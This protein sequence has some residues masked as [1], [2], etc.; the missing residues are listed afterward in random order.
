MLVYQDLLT[1]D[2]LLSDSFPYK[3]IEN[4]ILWEVEGKWTTVGAVDVNIGA[5]P[6]AEEGGEDEGVDDT[7]QKV[8][9]I[10]DTFRLQEQPTYDKKGFIA[11]IKKYIKLLTPKLNEE[12]QAAFKKGIEGATKFLLPKLNDFQ[13]FVGEGMHDDSTLVFAYY[14]E[15]ATNPTFLYFGHGLKEISKEVITSLLSP[16]H[17]LAFE[18]ESS[19]HLSL[20]LAPQRRSQRGQMQH[21]NAAAATA[22]YDAGPANDAGDAVMARW[23]QSAGLQHLASPTG[24]NDQRHLPSLLMQGYGAQTAEENQRLF[25]LMRNLNLNGESSESYTPTAAMPSSEGFFSPDFRGDFG[26]GL[27]DLHA[28]DDTELLSEHVSTEPFEPSPFMPSVDKEFE[29]GFNFPTNRQQQTDAEP[30]GS[31]PKSEKENNSVAKIKV[32]VRKRPLNKKETARKEDDVVTVSDN[33]LTVHEPKLKV[34]LTAYVERHEFCFDAVLDEDVSNDEV[35]R[36]TIEP[37]IPIIFQRTKAT[38]F[39]YGQTG[40]GKTYTM[41]PLPIRAVEDLMRL[42]RQPVYSNQ[43]FKLWLSYFEIYGGK[44]FDLLSERKKLLMREDGRQQV[45][46]VGLQEYEVSDVQIVKELIDKGNAERS[47]GSTGANEESSRSHAILQL[48]VKKHVEVKQTRRKNN[49]ATELPGKV[50]GKISFIDLAGSE[51]GADTTDNDRQTR[52]EG[53]EINK[54]LLALKE[55][56]RALDNDQLHIPFRGS[57]LTEVLRDSFVGNSRT[58]MISCISPSVGSCEHTVNTLR[59]ADRVKSLSKSGNSKKDLT[60]NS[61]PPVN[62]DSLLGS[63]DV[64][65]IFEP[66]QVV[67]VQETGR[68]VEKD[69][70][71]ASGIDFRQPTN[72]REESGIPSISM[73]KSRSET[74]NAFGGSNSQRNHLSSYPQETSDREEKAKKVSPPR[75]KGLREEK[76]DRPPQN[77]SSY[78]KETSDREEKVKKVSPPRGKGLR[79]EKPDRPPQNLSSYAKETSDRE[80]KVSPPRGKVLREE[81]P[82]RPPQNLSSYPQETSDREEKAKKVSPPRGKGL[83]EEKPDRPQ[84]LSKREVRSSDIPTFTNFRQNTSET[85]SRQYETEEN[86]DALLEEEEALITA[87]RKEI[88]DTMEI[89]REEMKLLA[90]VDKP[91]SMI[92]NY[93]TQLSFVLSRKAAGLVSLQARLARF[94]HRLKEQEILSLALSQASKRRMKRYFSDLGKHFPPLLLSSLFASDMEEQKLADDRNS[95]EQVERIEL[96]VSD[97]DARDTE[98]EVFEEAIDSSKPESFQADDGLHEDLP[99]EEVKV[100]EVN[101][102][103]HGEANLQHITTGEAATGFVTSQMN[104]DEGEAGA[105]NVN[106]TSTLSFSENGT[107]FPE[108]KQV[109]AEVIEETTNDGIEEENKEETVDVSGAQRNGERASGERSFSDSIQVA[110]AGTPSPSEKSSSEENGETEGRISREHDTVQNGGL[111]VEHTSQPNKDFEK[112]QGSSVNI[113]PEVKERKSEVASSVSPTES[114]SNTAASPPA[115]PAGLGRDAPLLEP[116]PRVPHQPRVNGNASQNQSEQAEDPTTAETD[117]HD[118]TREKLQLIRVKFL[119]LSHRLGQTPHNVVV[120]QVLYRLG[121]A[122]Q[123]R[124]RNGSRV[125]AFSF[126]RASSM[127]EQLEAAGQ[128]PLDFSCTVMV[129]GKSGVG[130]SATINSIFDEVKI[131]TDAFQMGT[132]RVQEVEGF[133]QG[134]KVRVIDTPGLLPSWSDQHKNEKMLKSVKAFIK[135]NP[136]DIVLYLDRLDMQSRDSGDTP[137]LRTITDVF[138]PSIWFNAIV[139]LTHAASAPPD[140]PNGTASSYDMFVTQRSHVI[141][142]A[143]RQAAGDMRLMNPV[144]LVENHSACR[145]NRAGQ[146]VLPNGQVWKPHLLLL[147]FASKILAEANALLKLQDNNTPGRPF[148]AR[149]K[150]PPL[151]LLLSSFLQSRP[152]AKLP[153]EQYGDEEDE[154][155]LDESSGSDEESE[156]D[157]LPPFKRLTKSEMAR[158]SK[159]QKK[160]YLDEMEYREKLF[161]KR[162]MKE[163]RKRRKMLKKF[164]AEIKEFANGHS[165]NVEEERSEPASVPVPMPDLSLPASFDSDNPTH[166]YRSLDS[167][168]QWLV[169]PVLE[170]QGWDH[171]VGYEGVNAER[172]FVVKEKIPISFS[173]QVTK[174]KKD[175]NVQLEM[176]SSVKHGEGRSTSLGFEMQNAGKELAYTVRSDTRFNNFRKHKAA[177]GLSVTLLGD[178]VSA[179][180]KVEDKLIANKRFRMVMCGGAMTSRGDV[181][182]GGSLEAQLRDKDYPLG[183][184]LSTLGLSLMDWHGDLAIGGNIQSQV[185]IG[186]SSNLIARANLNNRGTGQ[187]SVRV[188]SSEQLQLAMVALVPLFKKLFSY[189][190]PQQMQY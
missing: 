62:K 46:I 123:L 136:P 67:N 15:G 20:K 137:L 145:T 139:G 167:S 144:S 186:R 16:V 146:R 120:A 113:S 49:D 189:Y 79:E 182:Y 4:G 99:S 14:K 171:D 84:N 101:G 19:P 5:N 66:P 12:D 112:Q 118:E 128:D 159:S 134:I 77:L 53:A 125:G 179:G 170:T 177:A 50:V 156:Y 90:E 51:R 38:C 21:T 141:Q 173:G 190:S 138:G 91:G 126:D 184:F 37:I 168:N 105:E 75:G 165:E 172:L 41:K 59:Y 111:G 132:K 188:N 130:K 25:K 119:R 78:A 122:E 92:E 135:K 163:E 68:R 143:I 44:L 110:S 153:E 148:V 1:G 85:V 43:K 6:S 140:G 87:H 17:V 22:L 131:C 109:V 162:Q 81:K 166:R 98:D 65:D 93:V 181:A 124:G 86:I 160:Q 158:L 174:D 39:A 82:D 64:E 54:S 30:F 155:D 114:T 103:S 7:T 94:Q 107:V 45:C 116:T 178:S 27:M 40:S 9:D 13:F 169:R 34:D 70:Y 102:E 151:P 121:L 8:V 100:P 97:V 47:T 55:C 154:D 180:L 72:Y 69:N 23:L 3:E 185:P 157:Q 26:A 2:E 35:Y 95:D 152:Q 71:T 164:A 89:V 104:G 18:S 161:M 57:K 88:E 58:V 175:A 129:L 115:R 76:P 187:V 11:Y 149:S 106:E 142:Q 56:I 32:V 74:N 80:E 117:E 73:D 28:M 127:A 176:A 52:F 61:M 10:V 31:L 83:R 24:G 33:S 48:V 96:V 147:S 108:K 29:E 63:N 60:A 150:A 42:L 133:V 36:A 183:R